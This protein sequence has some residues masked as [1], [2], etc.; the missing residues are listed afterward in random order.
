MWSPSSP[1]TLYAQGDNQGSNTTNDIKLDFSKC[2]NSSDIAGTFQIHDAGGY[3][4]CTVS[5]SCSMA[6][7]NCT[8]PTSSS[9]STK[10]KCDVTSQSKDNKSISVNVSGNW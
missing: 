8:V 7:N 4:V 1:I 6:N 9:N 10:I 2:A 5:Y 3:N